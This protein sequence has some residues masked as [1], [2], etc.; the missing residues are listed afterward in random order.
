MVSLAGS[1]MNF[2][3]A[4]VVMFIW[5]VT[6]LGFESSQWT[7]ILSRV[8]QATILMN[9]GLGIF[10]LLPIPPLDGFGVLSGLLP[11][12][13]A[14]QL[15]LMEQYGLIILVLLLFTDIVNIVLYPTMSNIFDA[16]QKIITLI[17]TPFL[18]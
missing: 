8:F 11:G 17:L 1:I 18:G 7:E 13:Y 5:F 12:R 16:Y 15:K 4:F 2:L 6:M 14:P 10:N 9:L 3:V